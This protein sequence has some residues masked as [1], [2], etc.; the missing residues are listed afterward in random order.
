MIGELGKPYLESELTEQQSRVNEYEVM[1]ARIEHRVRRE[2]EIE[3]ILRPPK[4][5]L[6]AWIPH[7]LMW[8]GGFTIGFIV[9]GLLP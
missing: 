3:E 5:D 2:H 1:K 9:R 6:R 4:I 8:A 7:S